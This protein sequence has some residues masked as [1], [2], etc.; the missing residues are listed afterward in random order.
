[1][2]T[3]Q[4]HYQPPNPSLW[5][6]RTDPVRMHQ[7]ITCQSLEDIDQTPAVAILGFCSDE[8]VRRNH[9][10]QGAK[11]G[12]DAFRQALAPLATR[13]HQPIIDVGNIVADQDLEAAQ[14]ALGDAVS[15]LIQHQKWPLV[16]GGGHETAWG[17]FQGLGQQPFAAD[18]AIVNLDAHFDLRRE[19]QST[20]GT[21]FL[22]ISEWCQSHDLPFQ[23]YCYGIQ[24]QANTQ[25][26]FETANALKVEFKTAQEVMVTGL[27]SEIEK[28]LQ[29]HKSI[30]LTVCL[31]VFSA[32]FAP[33]VSAMSPVGLSPSDVFPVLQQLSASQQV[34]AMDIVEL[35]PNLDKDNMTAKLAAI[36]FHQF[37]EHIHG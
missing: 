16:I 30:Y 26:L 32:A 21:P 22:Q 25:I 18:I 12:P 31:D 15:W 24:P 29:T 10:R 27:Q 14:K 37:Y 28:I 35:A 6:G 17:H 8:G 7:C 4:K 3:W 36:L 11:A 34:V 19:Q 13:Q 20:S 23:Y 9:G 5:E 2:K 33:G 1:M